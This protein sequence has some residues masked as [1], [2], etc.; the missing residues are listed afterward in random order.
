VASRTLTSMTVSVVRK[1]VTF[2][3]AAK[4]VD[5]LLVAIPLRA[6]PGIGDFRPILSDLQERA[7]IDGTPRRQMLAKIV[8]PLGVVTE[9]VEGDICHRGR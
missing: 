5:L 2:E 1:T 7:L 3:G 6:R 8:L 9:R 4:V